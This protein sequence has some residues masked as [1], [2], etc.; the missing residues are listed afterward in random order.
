MCWMCGRNQIIRARWKAW[1]AV[2]LQGGVSQNLEAALRIGIRHIDT[3]QMYQ[4]H[5]DIGKTLAKMTAPGGDQE[6]DRKFVHVT[7]KVCV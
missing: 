7:S 2:V 3:A 1:D 5:T 4:N 6:I